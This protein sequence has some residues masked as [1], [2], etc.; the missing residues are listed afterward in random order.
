MERV[1]HSRRCGPATDAAATVGVLST[2]V[3]APS[4]S[5]LECDHLPP[6]LGMSRIRFFA[7]NRFADRCH[8]SVMPFAGASASV[9]DAVPAR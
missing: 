5:T 6:A 2:G 3:S 4:T 7:A 8:T 1:V 9:T